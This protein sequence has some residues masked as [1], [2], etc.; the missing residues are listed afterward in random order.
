RIAVRDHGIGISPGAQRR[1]FDRFER[2][3]SVRHYGG[4]GLGLYIARH[5]VEA[6]GGRIAV[7]SGAGQGASFTV[8]L[9]LDARRE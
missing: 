1:I 7:E 3:V 8:E 9:P 4:L 5:V 6:H 2:A